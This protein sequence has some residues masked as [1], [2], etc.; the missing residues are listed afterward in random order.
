MDIQNERAFQKQAPIFLGKQ[1]LLARK[2]KA[3]ELRYVKSIGLGFKTPKTAIEGTYIDKKCPFTGNVNIRGR[4][5]RGIV[6]SNKMNKTIIVRRDYLHYIPKYNRYEKRHKNIPAH[7]SPCFEC[8]E[9]DEVIIGECR[10]LS[11][12]VRFNVLKV[13]PRNKAKK[14]FTQF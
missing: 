2:L 9:G 14:Q 8:S 7:I 12:T 10:P 11:K 3:G 1:R 4:I 5:L 13:I 6:K